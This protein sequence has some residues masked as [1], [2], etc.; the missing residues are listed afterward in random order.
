M[1]KNRQFEE[2]VWQKTIEKLDTLYQSINDLKPE[3]S[4]E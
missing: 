4:D 2:I 3:I 1:E